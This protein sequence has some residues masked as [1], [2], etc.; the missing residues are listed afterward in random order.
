MFTSEGCSSCPSADKLLE[1]LDR[2]Q[3][4]PGADVIVLSEHVDYWNRL[5]W[6]DPY[7]SAAYTKRQ[8]DYVDTLNLSSAYTPQ[9]VVDGQTE[10]V[11]S[12]AAKAKAAVAKAVKEAKTAVTLGQ[13]EWVG[14]SLKVHVE[15]AALKGGREATVYIALAHN[16]AE[17]HVMRGENAGKSLQ[18]VAVVRSLTAVG[19]VGAGGGF[20]KDVSVPLKTG[21]GK[22]LRVVAFVQEQKTRRVLGVA[23]QKL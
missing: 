5:G 18:H 3:P 15:V 19:T 11:G 2:T 1:V 6:T 16:Q 21:P 12:D 10:L 23:Q 20:T 17:S 13:P 4:F 14:Q 8:S 22:N 9:L 7:S